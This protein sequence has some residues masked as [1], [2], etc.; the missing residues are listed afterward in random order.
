MLQQTIPVLEN[1]S[2]KM[3]QIRKRKDTD[4]L[5]E[6]IDQVQDS[7]E[8]PLERTGCFF[9]GLGRDIKRRFPHYLSDFTD[10]FDIHCIA[11][12]VF[13]YIASLAPAITFGGILSEKTG[14][15]I[16]VSETILATGL[17]GIIFAL[18]AGQPLTIISFTGPLVVFEK[19]TYVLSENL[20]IEY[21]PFRAWI[22]IWVMFIC[23]IIVAFE[24]C[25]LVRYFTRF[26]EEIFA[27]LIAFTFIYDAVHIVVDEYNSP[28]T[29][30][31]TISNITTTTTTNSSASGHLA[32]LLV[33]GTFIIS[34]L[35]RR[36]RHSHFFQHLIR[37]IVSDF[38]VLIAI[39]SM[40]W[41]YNLDDDT[42]VSQLVVPDGFDKTKAERIGW[43]V[44]PMGTNNSMG[45]LD[46]FAAMIPAI[47][48]SI[49][50]FMEVE[51]TG[52]ILDKKEFKL[53][54]GTGY[55]LDLIVVGLIVCLC[56]MLGFP[57]LCASPIHS[58]SHLHALMVFDN[59][60]APGE[61]PLLVEV[62]EQRV[63]NMVIHILIG[64]SALLAP[65]LRAVPIPVLAGVLLYLG[66]CSLSHIQLCE[67]VKMLFMP[68]NHHPD[69]SYVLKV[70]TKKMHT[71]TII[72][73][74]CVFLI[75]LIKLTVLAPAFPFFVLCLIPLR[76][77][78]V[79]W[80]D[81]QELEVLDNETEE[82][83]EDDYDE[84]DAVHVPI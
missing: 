77:S 19:S 4:V 46:I 10:V 49:L 41:Y 9:G 22:G 72:Q 84:F 30:N 51:L 37:R 45:V 31:T 26:T 78:L 59:N 71:F 42:T 6:D 55:N 58:V 63:T 54:K 40:V 1:Q 44:N 21:L 24:G 27:C 43:F 76:K 13:V 15:W 81:E 5:Q 52:V 12:I 66:I 3:F 7:V 53:K 75:I 48:V 34:Y 8:D 73:T 70:K 82:M 56:S 33:F 35:F 80:F 61:R 25:F 20:D 65:I 23:F 39:L 62:K 47:L 17:A 64:L 83:N 79:Y 11:A 57:W 16:G 2:R 74:I 38:G 60:Q 18:L 68:P 50:I 32:L 29:V 67:R 14:G 69:V 28:I 36:F